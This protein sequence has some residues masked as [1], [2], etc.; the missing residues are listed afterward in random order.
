MLVTPS[1]IVIPARLLGEKEGTGAHVE[2]LLLKRRE[3]DVWETLVKPG[4]KAKPGTK[5]IFGNGLLVGEVVDA[6][7]IIFIVLVDVLM[8]TYQENKA[9]NSAEAL[10]KLVT[11]KVK[12][13]RN[14]EMIKVDA[15]ELTIGDIVMLESGDKISADMRILESSNLAVDESILTGESVQVEKNN[16]VIYEH[17]LLEEKRAEQAKTGAAS[18]KRFPQSKTKQPVCRRTEIGSQTAAHDGRRIPRRS[19]CACANA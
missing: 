4:K 3:G 11:T 16:E 15:S 12:V 14:N 19:Q 18:E 13:I 10:K 17:A 9:N 1:G 2:V 6:I 5:I 7:A 8:G